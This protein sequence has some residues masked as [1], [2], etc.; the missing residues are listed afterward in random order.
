MAYT[1]MGVHTNAYGC[2]QSVQSCGVLLLTGHSIYSNGLAAPQFG[3]A[4]IHV[5]GG[6]Y[7][8]YQLH[9]N[10]EAPF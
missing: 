7:M 9:H 8:T 4:S 10:L 1:Q 3:G 5:W 6:F 2:M